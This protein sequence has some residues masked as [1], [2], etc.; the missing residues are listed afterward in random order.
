MK[1]TGQLQLGAVEVVSL[2]TDELL[3]YA[4]TVES[5]G[6]QTQRW[7]LY[8][9]PENALE[10][11]PPPEAMVRWT[12]GDWQ[13]NVSGLWKPNSF[14]V[15]AQ[16]TIHPY[17]IETGVVWTK[18]P[19][20]RALPPVRYP[21][22]DGADLQIDPM[23]RKVL[24]LIQE[25]SRGLVFTV[26]GLLDASNAEYW[27]LPAGYQPAGSC[28]SK[29]AVGTED[30]ESLQDFVDVANGSWGPGCM[31]VITGCINYR[32]EIAPRVP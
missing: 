12:L 6:G 8:R 14:Y 3:G 23:A 11:R 5:E 15:W 31:L 29:V 4:Y 24:H 20:A 16:S 1:M 17:E 13:S 25:R 27:M 26:G 22:V 19:P 18:I 2:G 10:L 30:A 9:H 28:A 32:G 7:L 21:D